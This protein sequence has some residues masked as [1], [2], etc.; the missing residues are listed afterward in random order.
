MVIGWYF[1]TKVVKLT[2]LF[3]RYPKDIFYL[4]VSIAF[5]LYHGFIKLNALY[6]WNEVSTITPGRL[7]QKLTRR[8]TNWGSRPDGDVDNQERMAPVPYKAEV[9][10]NPLRS[11]KTI[12]RY[13]DEVPE[14]N[15]EEKR[16][17]HTHQLSTFSEKTPAFNDDEWTVIPQPVCVH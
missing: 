9:M 5:G 14:K 3:R 7:S 15:M 13:N 6:T 1:F 10:N 4:P 2:G 16:P 11:S 8:Q 17:I 12:V